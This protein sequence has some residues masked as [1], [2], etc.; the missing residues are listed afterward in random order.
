MAH[1]ALKLCLLRIDL[2]LNFKYPAVRCSQPSPPLCLGQAYGQQE[3][4]SVA[5]HIVV[6]GS[7]LEILGLQA[8]WCVDVCHEDSPKSR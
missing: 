5:N 7:S 2:A 1:S 4:I 8:I 6:K 3:S